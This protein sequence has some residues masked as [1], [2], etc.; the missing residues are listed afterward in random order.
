MSTEELNNACGKKRNE[1]EEM[2]PSLNKRAKNKVM[3]NN[4]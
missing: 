3:K 1:N 2:W 4:K